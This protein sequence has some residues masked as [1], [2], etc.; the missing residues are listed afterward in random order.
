MLNFL[1]LIYVDIFR[2]SVLE[3]IQVTHKRV[4]KNKFGK[5]QKDVISLWEQEGSEKTALFYSELVD[6]LPG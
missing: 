2:G 5:F 1:S 4:S 6:L 3:C